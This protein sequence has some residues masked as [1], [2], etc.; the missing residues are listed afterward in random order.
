MSEQD[1][2]GKQEW[3]DRM[4]RVTEQGKKT[5]HYWAQQTGIA[6]KRVKNEACSRLEQGKKWVQSEDNIR[7]RQKFQ[8]PVMAALAVLVLV[9]SVAGVM[10]QRHREYE[11]SL[12]AYEVKM[13]GETLGIL[14]EQQQLD[15]VLDELRQEMRHLYGMDAYIPDEREWLEVRATDEEITG[16]EGIKQ[17]IKE[18][19]GIQVMATAVTVEGEPLVILPSRRKAE[20]LLDTLMEPYL[21]PIVSYLEI[22]FAETVE[23]KEVPVS[24]ADVWD[25]EQGLQYLQTGTTETRTHVVEPGE[26]S[27]LI[28]SRLDMTVEEIEAANPGIRADR[29]SIGQELNLVVP[30]PYL[31]VETVEYAELAEA[32]PF[33]T[34]EV[35]S[36]NLYAGDRRITVQGQEGFHEIKA[37]IVRHNG[38]EVDRDVLEENRISEPTT[39]VVAVGTKPRPATM[40]TGSF[41]N[42]TTGRLTSPFGMR[43]GRRHTG[44]DVAAST[45]TSVRAADAGRVSFAGTRGAYGRLV[46]IDHENGYQTYYAHLNT[47]SV[48]AGTRVHKDQTLGTMGSTGRSTG[49]HLH[50][51]VRKN[52][53]P[54]NPLSFVSY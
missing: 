15:E 9:V 51:E 2:P 22:G 49:P 28:A 18:Q 54:V 36:G 53:T 20:E 39:R 48:S 46:I 10:L 34:E 27:W 3:K 38:R 50:F 35:P 23:L 43:A 41:I 33:D 19:L 37:H 4:H 44:I 13:E 32:I 26:S 14:R 42:P 11:E 6:M 7:K 31:N 45:G 17:A 5:G 40:A 1:R 25:M 29:L 16:R 12:V 30:V 52:G 47:I 21:D 8:R 24:V